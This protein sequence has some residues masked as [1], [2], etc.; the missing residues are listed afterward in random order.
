MQY[1][2][3]MD[4][5]TAYATTAYSLTSSTILSV[6]NISSSM[7]YPVS[8]ATFF[9]AFVSPFE[10]SILV[11]ILEIMNPKA[12]TELTPILVISLMADFGFAGEGPLDGYHQLR[13]LMAYAI[14][15]A[16]QLQSPI[17]NS[18][19][20]SVAK[21]IYTLSIAPVTL[22]IFIVFGAVV[23]GWCLLVMAWAS[24]RVTANTSGF[25]EVD[26]AAKWSSNLLK[27]LSNAESN[28]VL[29]K[30]GG[31]KQ[32]YLGEGVGEKGPKVV[33]DTTRATTKLSHGVRYY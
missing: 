13:N 3:K 14:Q 1:A 11:R 32:V 27:G 16:S 30:V 23:L 10:Q 2:T 31:T 22:Y 21:I 6:R 18:S 12:A 28:G 15:A 24:T 5:S 7:P 33:L 4:I 26:F 8:V 17:Q 29:K 25:P 19:K 9:Q 20:Q